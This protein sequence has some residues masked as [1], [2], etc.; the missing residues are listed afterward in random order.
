[1]I[2]G[3]TFLIISIFSRLL[4]TADYGIYNS[5]VAYEAIGFVLIVIINSIIGI[6]LFNIFENF[7]GGILALDRLSLNLLLLYSFAYNIFT[8]INV[9]STSLGAVWEPWFFERMNVKD[10]K[11]I[12]SVSALYAAGMLVFSVIMMLLSP[13]I[14]LILGTSDYSDAV[15]CVV[16]IVAGEY[17]AFIDYI[18][19]RWALA[20]LLDV[21]KKVHEIC[22]ENDIKYYLAYGTLFGAIRH[23]GYIPW[24]DD[25]EK[26]KERILV[27]FEGTKLWAPKKYEYILSKT[28]GDYMQLPPEE[29]RKPYHGYIIVKKEDQ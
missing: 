22:E 6:V 14:I 18:I 21:L 16:P 24:D 7:I 19:I 26:L 15:Y 1:M 9:T 13:E 20:I 11:G 25:T 27:D 8:I 10:Y 29:D 5:F 3:L 17:F 2:K 4:S 23:K 12:R 28:Y